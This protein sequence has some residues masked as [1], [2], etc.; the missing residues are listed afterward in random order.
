[1]GIKI[2]SYLRKNF[3]RDNEILDGK[4]AYLLNKIV[5]FQYVSISVTIWYASCK[6]AQSK[7]G[8]TLGRRA[9]G[10]KG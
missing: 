5:Y 10:L 6:S 1:M 8:E 9:T 7:P 4:T 3:T 2:I